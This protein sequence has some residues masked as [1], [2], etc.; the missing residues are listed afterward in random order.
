M[1]MQVIEIAQYGPPE[2]L[3]VKEREIPTPAKGEVLIR[4]DASGVCRAYLV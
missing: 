3:Q 2:V 1:K 4:M